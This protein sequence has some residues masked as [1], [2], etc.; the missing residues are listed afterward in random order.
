MSKKFSNLL[1]AL[2]AAGSLNAAPGLPA[3]SLH[4][5]PEGRS[6]V[7]VNGT[8]LYNRALYGAHS[9]FRMECSDTP[10]FGIYLP[11]MGGNL[12]FKLPDGDCKAVYTAGRMDYTQGGVEIEAQVTRTSDAALWRLTNTTSHEVSVPVTF[13]GVS[14]KNFSRNGDLGVDK[15]DCFELKPQYCVGNKLAFSGDRL[16]VEF[17]TKKRREISLIIPASK[18]PVGDDNIFHG[19]ITLA[20]G[21]RKV[22]AYYP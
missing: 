4:Y 19:T 12:S 13:G 3:R 16:T 2:V 21:Q 6:A 9:G 22:V 14:G 15:P 11:G 8:G 7:C 10:V 20:P 18:G 17:G 5:Q 1:L